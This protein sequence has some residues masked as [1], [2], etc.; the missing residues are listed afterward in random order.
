[1]PSH[2]GQAKLFMSDTAT[3]IP[4]PTL[5]QVRLKIQR[6]TSHP[7][8]FQ[9]M[10]EWPDARLPPGAIVDVIDRDG[11]WVGRGFF[12]GHSRIAL[13]ILTQKQTEPVDAA[14]IA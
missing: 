13:R 7:W 4:A 2:T 14:F 6:R 8:V 5:P 1:M 3:I 9:K 11:L 12:N 10:V